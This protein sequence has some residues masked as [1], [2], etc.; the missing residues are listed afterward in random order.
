MYVAGDVATGSS[1]PAGRLC[2]FYSIAVSLEKVCHENK[3]F[4][5]SP[6]STALF[7]GM[8]KMCSIYMYLIRVND[9]GMGFH[10]MNISM[11][12]KI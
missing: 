4:L 1:T 3:V 10:A 9:K 12:L 8:K 6:R 2:I 5:I 7:W 11:A